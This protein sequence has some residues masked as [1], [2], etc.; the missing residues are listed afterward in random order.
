MDMHSGYAELHSAAV[1]QQHVLAYV[2]LVKRIVRQLASQTGGAI[3]REDMEQIGLLGLLDCLR[4]YGTPDDKFGA[5]AALRVRGAILDE[6]RRQDWRPRSVR[7]ESHRLRDAARDLERRL[8]H[9]PSEAELMQHLALTPEAYQAYVMAENAEQLA[10]FDELMQEMGSLPSDAPSPEAQLIRR[11]SIEQ[12]LLALDEREQRVVQL[13][14][15][16]DLS[17]KEIAAVL[18]LTEARICQINKGA[19]R[20]MRDSLKH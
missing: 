19:L 7:Q 17:L 5:Y 10:S 6:L 13:Y 2:P 1:E 11:R 20:K 3:D 9:E 18:D 14:Y 16:F 15:E 12:A 4:R 8:G